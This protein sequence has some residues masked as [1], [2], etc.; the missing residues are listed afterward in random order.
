MRHSMYLSATRNV[1]IFGTLLACICDTG[2]GIRL[3]WRWKDGARKSIKQLNRVSIRVREL[4]LVLG[5]VFGLVPYSDL[6]L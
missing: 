6:V 5:L 2:T 4:G 3:D 1:D